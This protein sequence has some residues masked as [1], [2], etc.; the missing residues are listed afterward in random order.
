MKIIIK[1]SILLESPLIELG[2]ININRNNTKKEDIDSKMKELAEKGYILKPV[3]CY[4][5]SGRVFSEHKRNNCQF[6][7]YLYGVFAFPKDFDLSEESVSNVYKDYTMYA[8]GDVYDF[9]IISGSGKIEN[10]FDFFVENIDYQELFENGSSIIEEFMKKNKIKKSS[11][12]NINDDKRFDELRLKYYGKNKQGLITV[13][14]VEDGEWYNDI[15]G[16]EEVEKAINNILK[17][18]N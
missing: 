10:V 18:K 4:E 9:M 13:K 7:N 11:I 17:E 5:H 15:Y 14:E 3:Y 1:H 6:D 2:I 8:E 12:E 16:L